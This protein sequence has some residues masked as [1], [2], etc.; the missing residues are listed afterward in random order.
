MP[1]RFVFGVLIIHHFYQLF[2]S[3]NSGAIQPGVPN[4]S[5]Y[6]PS[7]DRVHAL[8]KS[9][10]RVSSHTRA[11]VK[12]EQPGLTLGEMGKEL[13]RLWKEVE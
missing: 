5:E 1:T 13:G 4:P 2:T 8:P 11:G 10:S 6:V 9:Q 7:A 12:V 3:A